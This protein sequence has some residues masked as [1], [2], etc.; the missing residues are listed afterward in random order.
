MSYS[1]IQIA[2]FY[3][4]LILV[5]NIYIDIEDDMMQVFCALS[6]GLRPSSRLS[7]MKAERGKKKNFFCFSYIKVLL[8]RL[9]ERMQKLHLIPEAII[10]IISV[11]CFCLLPKCMSA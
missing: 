6:W 3:S 11:F 1:H 7:T 8:Q 10:G 5:D 2:I 4:M 9:N